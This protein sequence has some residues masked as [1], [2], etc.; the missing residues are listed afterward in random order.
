VLYSSGSEIAVSAG[1]EEGEEILNN[2]D[3][4]GIKDGVR[5]R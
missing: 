3:Q 1:L 5:I 2:I 4:E